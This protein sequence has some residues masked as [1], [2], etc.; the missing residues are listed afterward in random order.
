MR[1]YTSLLILFVAFLTIC[2][3][4]RLPSDIELYYPDED[5]AVINEELDLPPIPFIYLDG[6]SNSIIGRNS[7]H[8]F[9]RKATIG[10]VL[11]YDK[12][13]S[14]DGTISC[15]SCHKQE[16]AFSDDVAFSKGVHDNLT[17][18]N[19]YPIGSFRSLAAEYYESTSSPRPG[20]FWD[21][22]A[23]NVAA[24]MTETL[25]NP[26]EMGIEL[27]ELE[28]IVKSKAYYQSLFKLA[29]TPEVDFEI[30]SANIL[31]SLQDFM[32]TIDSKESKFDKNVS[33]DARFM[34]SEDRRNFTLSEQRGKLLFSN[35]CNKCHL[36]TSVRTEEGRFLTQR[37]M[38]NNGL[39]KVYKDQ[40][41]G[42]RPEFI[43]DSEYQGVFKVPDLRNIALTGPYMH[44]GRF[45][46]LDDVIDH[47]SHGVKDHKNLGDFLKDDNGE[48]MQLNFTDRNKKDLINFLHT[49]TDP[50]LVTAEKW[51]DPFRR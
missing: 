51:S 18:R 44:D 2:C 46:T 36:V 20:L 32:R 42:S 24:Q 41:K 22:R 23:G 33:E 37:E 19:S 16:L 21:E 8:T 17:D 28:S 49:L 5:W 35:S 12:S 48:A 34:E 47:Y 4:N 25:A 14:A 39:D 45:A 9:E 15:A 3:E 10:R 26:N 13:L 27:D 31:E 11:F 40:G 1:K 43:S 6:R 38:T 7:P 29:G 50:D 30:T